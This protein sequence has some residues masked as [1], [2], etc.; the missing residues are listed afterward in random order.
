MTKS[1]AGRL[2]GKATYKRHGRDHMSKIGKRG[3]KRLCCKFLLHSRRR[4]LEYLNG[5]GRMKARYVK[6][7]R[8][9]A[10]QQE[11]AWAELCQRFGLDGPGPAT[12]P[13]EAMPF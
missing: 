10:A 4:A 13:A 8:T 7:E 12:P 3:F 5:K 1:E 6:R 11:A 9:T 2:G